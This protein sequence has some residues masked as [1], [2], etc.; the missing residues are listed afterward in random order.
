MLLTTH[1]DQSAEATTQIAALIIAFQ[2][3]ETVEPA[4]SKK[5]S[6]PSPVGID[7]RPRL[8][9]V[10][11]NSINL[12]L[13]QTFMKKRK[14]KSVDLAEN[15]QLAVDAAKANQAGYDVIFMGKIAPKSTTSLSPQSILIK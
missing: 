9:L 6:L 3:E 1:F 4:D 10:D 2:N 5:L 8:L 12:R 15:G 11:D 14:Y 13:L 7:N